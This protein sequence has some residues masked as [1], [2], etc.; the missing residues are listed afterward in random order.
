MYIFNLYNEIIVTATFLA[1]QRLLYEFPRK[2]YGKYQNVSHI[3]NLRNGYLGELA[4]L[5]LMTDKIK[6]KYSEDLNILKNNFSNKEAKQLYDK[7]KNENFSWEAVIG[8]TDSGYDFR[9]D[10][11][12]ID[13]KTY[14]TDY[15]IKKDDNYVLFSN[16]SKN[17]YDL[18]LLVDERQGKK[19]ENNNNIIFVQTF[20]EK[21]NQNN[22]KNLIF[23]GYYHGLPKLNRK[24]PNPAYA[25]QVKELKPMQKLFNL[26]G[27]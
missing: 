1:K 7:I 18:N 13:I 24:F 11:Y 4:F 12:L 25:C 8:R 3:E 10:D 27:V 6:Q 23:A 26:L 20:I 16:E 2:G 15:I 21:D 5:E 19:W 17:I 14:G 22:I 9:K